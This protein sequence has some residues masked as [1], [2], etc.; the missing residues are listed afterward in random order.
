[1]ALRDL[2]AVAE[3]AAC[4]DPAALPLIDAAFDRSGGPEAKELRNRYCVHCPIGGM[5]LGQAMTHGEWGPWGGTSRGLRTSRG[6][7]KP[8][9]L[10]AVA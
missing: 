1:M 6:A 10:N 7:P 3:R 8:P 9:M 5:C 2:L 4:S